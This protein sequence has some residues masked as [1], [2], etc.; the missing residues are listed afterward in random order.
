MPDPGHHDERRGRKPVSTK[1]GAQGPKKAGRVARH[2]AAEGDETLGVVSS[3]G[4]CPACNED[5]AFLL[6]RTRPSYERGSSHVRIVDLFAGGGG[7]SLGAVEAARRAG[8]AAEVVL[9]VERHRSAADVYE[10]NF[11]DADLRRS[12]VEALFDGRLGSERT[13]SERAVARSVGAVD[14]LVAG[15]P[16][17]GNSDLNNHTRRTDPRNALYLLAVRGVEVLRPTFVLI[18]NVPAV[19]HAH[20]DVVNTA[21]RVLS[22]AGYEVASDVLDLT[23]FGVPQRRRRHV[24][25]AVRGVDL[26]PGEVLQTCSPCSDHGERTVRWAIEDLL[27]RSASTGLDAPS[28]PTKTNLERMR[29][30]LENGECDLPNALRPKCHHNHHSYVSMYGRLSWDKPAQTITTG[31][32]SMGQGRFV[33]PARPRTITP[34]EAGRLQTLP[35]FFDLGQSKSRSDWA[36][37]IGNAVPPL[38]GVHLIEPLLCALPAARQDATTRSEQA[39]GRSVPPASSEQIRRRM[40]TT[41]RRDTKPELALRSALHGLGLRFQV[42]RRINGSRCRTDVVFPTERV[43]V[44]VDGCFWHGCP[45]HGTIP[46]QNR[47]WWIEKLDA[48]KA[49]DAATT[50]ALTAEGWQVLRFWEHEDAAIAAG[51]VHDLVVSLRNR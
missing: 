17:Q 43:A 45:E 44:Y 2:R 40:T 22:A 7:L 23:R 4:S 30:L 16:C 3:E 49:R 50:A 29:W 19:Q 47:D 13:K 35:D 24:L 8:R 36:M 25:L 28:R 21:V 10:L 9:A 15:P 32:G 37:V 14:V 26:D 41:R 1:S 18:E 20:A 31:Y 11:P 39:R 34:H 27:E 5:L 46:K 51:M 33:H 48:N 6:R 12:E 38:L 42:D